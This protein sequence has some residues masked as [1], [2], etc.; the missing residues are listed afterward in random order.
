VESKDNNA[1]PKLIFNCYSH[2]CFLS[3]IWTGSGQGRKLVESSREKEVS[4][5]TAE[6]ELAVVTL[7]LTVTP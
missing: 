2:E 7:P 5:A 4:R 3:E 1:Q 6:N